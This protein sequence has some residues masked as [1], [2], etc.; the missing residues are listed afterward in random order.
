MSIGKVRKDLHLNYSASHG[1]RMFYNNKYKND[2]QIIKSSEM[3][4]QLKPRL[5]R[6][7]FD[8]IF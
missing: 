4:T 7:V 6:L 3:L 1:T 5:Q 8:K 2:V